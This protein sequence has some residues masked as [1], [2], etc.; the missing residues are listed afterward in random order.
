MEEFAK[1]FYEY[2]NLKPKHLFRPIIEECG[3]VPKGL[4]DLLMDLLILEKI[5]LV[6][7]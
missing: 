4:V 7:P 1:L 3:A 2:L 6:D 5:G